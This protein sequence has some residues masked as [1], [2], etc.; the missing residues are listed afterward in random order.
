MKRY[1]ADP[2]KHREQKRKDHAKHR[3]QRNASMRQ[4][5]RDNAEDFK[6]NV[7]IWQV[8]NQHLVQQY[9][10]GY[11]RRMRRESPEFVL[12]ER[13]RARIRA[14]VVSMGYDKR[15]RTA[16]I[17]GCTWEHFKAH[18]ES[19]FV[20]GMSWENI[21]QWHLDHHVPLCSARDLKDVY[22][23]NHWTNI[24]PLWIRD[25]LSKGARV[26]VEPLVPTV[27]SRP[28]VLQAAKRSPRRRA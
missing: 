10:S 3:K 2:E 14:S 20:P 4:R 23:L 28:K 7:R 6:E 12:A 8:N 5:Y 1:Y 11:K 13:L 26:P 19:L 21:S 16:E 25:N 9:K 24:K 15:S 18:I 22:A 27:G 17:L